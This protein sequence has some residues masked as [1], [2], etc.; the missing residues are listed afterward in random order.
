MSVQ[1]DLIES[2]DIR[3][4]GEQ[5]PLYPRIVS[6]GTIDQNEFLDRVS[7]FTGLS[8]S[9]L[10]GA[11]ESFQT[12]LRDLLANGWNVELGNIGYFSA[13]L[14]CPPIMNKKE[15]RST[16]VSLKNINFRAS[17]LLKKEVANQM[18]LE[19]YGNDRPKADNK[20]T[21]PTKSDRLRLLNKYL[22]ANPCIN[23]VQYSELTGCKKQNAIQEL[24]S[25]IEQG[26]IKKHG[27]GKLVV[28]IR[29]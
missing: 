12:E 27:V 24:N 28:Y 19:R 21:I 25:F 26:I 5:Q 29:I 17:S 6:K 9:L 18:R 8:R 3:Q 14:K 1:Y 10:S 7:K 15:I 13:S 11:M 2:P 23:R 22:D 4:T 16:S 20:F